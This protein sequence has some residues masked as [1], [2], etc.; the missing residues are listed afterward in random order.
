MSKLYTATKHGIFWESID[1]YLEDN[2]EAK[3]LWI[4]LQMGHLLN[5]GHDWQG[6]ITLPVAATLHMERTCC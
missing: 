4:P 5:T 6:R 3:Y 1:D 2:P